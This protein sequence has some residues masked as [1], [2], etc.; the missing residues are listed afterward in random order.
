MQNIAQVEQI[1]LN[2]GLHEV[3]KVNR[4]IKSE[5]YGTDAGKSEG[6]IGS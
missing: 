1:G 5:P 3:D 2:D 6:R 4:R